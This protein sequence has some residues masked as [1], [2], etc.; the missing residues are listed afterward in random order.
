MVY[1]L[2]IDGAISTSDGK[3]K[4]HKITLKGLRDL[5]EFENAQN[6]KIQKTTDTTAAQIPVDHRQEPAAAPVPP[7]AE[8]LDQQLGDHPVEAPQNETEP[9]EYEEGADAI[10]IQSDEMA[11]AVGFDSA[12]E[13][14]ARDGYMILDPANPEDYFVCDLVN[15]LKRQKPPVLANKT[16]KV[17]LLKFM[18]SFHGKL[19]EDVDRVLGD[20]IR[21]LESLEAA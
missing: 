7:L 11:S 8:A 16:E 17:Q 3:N 5:E 9:V 4:M 2:R 19:N 14:L 13:T 20:I 21:Y 15:R 1:K 6:A 12:I 10:E 18:Q